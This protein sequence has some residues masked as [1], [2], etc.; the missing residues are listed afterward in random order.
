MQ[1]AADAAALG[2]AV[3]M[4]DNLA[5]AVDDS[6]GDRPRRTAYTRRPNGVTVSVTKGDLPTQVEGHDQQDRQQL[7]R[8]PR[9]RRARRRS[10]STRSGSTRRPSTWAARSTSSAT[11]RP[12]PAIT[13]GSTTLS[14]HLGQRVRA[15]VE[16]GQGRRDPRDGLPGQH[17]QLLGEQRRLRRRRLLL[18][19][20]GRRTAAI[21]P[22]NFEAFDPEFAH[23][24]DNCGQHAATL[25]GATSWRAA[26]APN[27]N[28]QFAVA[29]PSVRYAIA[30]SSPYCS[31]DMYY[32]DGGNEPR[33]PWTT[34]SRSRPDDTPNDPTNNPV[35]VLDELPGLHRRPAR[36]R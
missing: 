32:T 36:P 22:L 20:R 33:P 11:T 34:F 16:Q 17:R 9:R 23:V 18:R 24:G 15:V 21:G 31:G 35:A 5:T 1:K 19:R 26:L 25:P 3:F 2:G 7:L 6:Q 10:A 27:F 29:N 12:R 28:P 30:A 14:R 13:H 8:R 4:P